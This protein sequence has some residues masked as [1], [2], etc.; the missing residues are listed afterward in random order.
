MKCV[1]EK[2]IPIVEKQRREASIWVKYQKNIP[3]KKKKKK[4]NTLSKFQKLKKIKKK[5]KDFPLPLFLPSHFEREKNGRLPSDG[6]WRVPYR[7]L[8]LLLLLLLLLVL[9]S[10]ARMEKKA[11]HWRI[12][13]SPFPRRRR[14]HR[15]GGH[16]G[17]EREGWRG[18]EQE[19]LGGIGQE[20]GSEQRVRY[21]FWNKKNLALH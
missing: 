13:F 17:R 11:V 9:P 10:P 8:H 12:P 19:H 1:R 5:K 6:G 18:E 21:V 16:D 20:L 15:G 7:P 2:W 14:C 3:T 4:S